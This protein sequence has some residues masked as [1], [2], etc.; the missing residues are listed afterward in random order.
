MYSYDTLSEALND[1]AK[2]GFTHDFNLESDHIQ[3][4]ASGEKIL[5]E[6]F[7]I[8][9]VYRFE[10]MTSTDDEAVIY[11]VKTSG[12]LKGILVD[13]YGTYANSLSREMI[14]RL[15]FEPKRS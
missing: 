5:P 13:A 15:K 3:N 14:A 9:E 12:G 4:K 10:G 7:N 11:A 6:Y 2:R 8:L 1:L